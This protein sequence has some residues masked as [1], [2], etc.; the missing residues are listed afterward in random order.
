MDFIDHVVEEHENYVAYTLQNFIDDCGALIGLFLG[1]SI[2]SIMELIYD[3]IKTCVKQKFNK[4]EDETLMYEDDDEM[5]KENFAR[6]F[7]NQ[8]SVPGLNRILGK[9]SFKVAK[10]MWIL[11]ILMSI[12]GLIF[13]IMVAYIKLN[14]IPDI[15][16]TTYV[17]SSR[18]IPLPA[19]TI[20]SSTY[21]RELDLEYHPNFLL[22]NTNLMNLTSTEKNFMAA[23]MQVCGPI[24]NS[25]YYKEAY[26]GRTEVNVLKLLKNATYYDKLDHCSF[27]MLKVNCDRFFQKSLT[28]HGVCWTF[29][30]QSYSNILN[31]NILSDD[32][33]FLMNN[34]NEHDENLWTLEKG[35]ET[36]EDEI[37]PFRAEKKN[38]VSLELVLQIN[39]TK[40]NRFAYCNLMGAGYKLFFH[41]PN[42]I[43]TPFS[44][45]NFMQFNKEFDFKIS[46]TASTFDE[47]TLK[48][49]PNIR[50]CYFDGERQLKFFK[51]YT[52][53]QCDFECMT[54]YTLKA[55]G[56]VKFS[57]PRTPDTPMCDLEHGKCLHYALK[58]W[59]DKTHGESMPC[60][61]FQ[62][63]NNIEYKIDHIKK[64]DLYFSTHN[65]SRR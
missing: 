20:C 38:F 16:V 13:Y 56:C 34:K 40:F 47:N 10:I 26:K 27:K 25:P 8:D 35:Y 42:E 21:P 17:K 57:M 58:Q 52:R 23:Y 32:Y 7:I 14:V 63:C 44:L 49:S 61:C 22:Q 41:L 39:L 54:N 36:E 19:I 15:G 29:N 48:Y 37:F 6:Y 2:L 24:F 5:D 59:S 31:E 18:D 64:E 28:D 53:A 3:V 9:N 46:A 50:K 1:L 11:A 12:C 60:D 43:P 45:Q 55:C 30:M 4:I 51:T 33:D 65:N 62:P